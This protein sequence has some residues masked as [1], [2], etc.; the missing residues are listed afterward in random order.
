ML[1]EQQN[2]VGLQGS[3]LFPRVAVRRFLDEATCMAAV[4]TLRLALLTV[5]CLSSI[6]L[7]VYLIDQLGHPGRVTPVTLAMDF[8]AVYCSSEALANGQDPYRTVPATTCQHAAADANRIV[9]IPGIVPSVLPPY[10]IVAIEPLARLS[11]PLATRVWFL[12]MIA[13]FSGSVLLMTR[14]STLPIVVVFASLFFSSFIA[15]F[16]EGQVGPVLTVLIVLAGWSLRQRHNALAAACCCAL[17]FEPHVGAPVVLAAFFFVR[18][19]RGWIAVGTLTIALLTLLADPRLSIEYLTT[20]LP[21]HNLSEV[22]WYKQ[23]SLTALLWI[24]GVSV[25]NAQTLGL[26]SYLA[27]VSASFVLTK[28]ALDR[29]G[30]RAYAIF[31]PAAC[32]VFGGPFVHVFQVCA[33]IPLALILAGHAGPHRRLAILSVLLLGLPAQAMLQWS[34]SPAAFAFDPIRATPHVH[35]EL[36]DPNPIVDEFRLRDAMPTAYI[37][38]PAAQRTL[39]PRLW[40]WCGL[41]LVLAALIVRLREHGGARARQEELVLTTVPAN[42]FYEPTTPRAAHGGPS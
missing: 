16:G 35:I 6:L 20:V 41:L 15:S 38:G 3:G 22:T 19:L 26:A 2:L 42:A 10:A 25:A 12:I 1:P 5:V 24:E 4:F 29:T 37:P 8:R 33:A 11:F 40:T 39:L 28:M 9:R 7:Y 17:L 34:G 36:R 27:M 13:A 31:I 30:D 32:A 18:P 14:L 23:Y 21:L